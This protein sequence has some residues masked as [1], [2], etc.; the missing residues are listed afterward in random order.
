MQLWEKLTSNCTVSIYVC[1]PVSDISV[2][3]ERVGGELDRRRLGR[4]YKLRLL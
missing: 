3:H 2:R 1:D 4:V